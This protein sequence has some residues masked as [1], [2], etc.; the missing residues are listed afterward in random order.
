MD[1]MTPIAV[2]VYGTLM[3]GHGNHH[4]L[5]GSQF[6]G[7]RCLPGV[8]L[9]DLGPF[10]MAIRATDARSHSVFGELWWINAACLHNLD[11]LEGHPRLYQRQRLR[12]SNGQQAWVYLGRPRQVRHSPLLREG[13]WPASQAQASRRAA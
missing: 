2:F 7:E 1:Q 8:Q 6:E 5:A 10:P 3:R 11:R 13:R 4:W 9:H 12:L